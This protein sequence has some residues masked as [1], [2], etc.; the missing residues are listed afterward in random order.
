MCQ[1]HLVCP[2]LQSRAARI[3]K[4]SSCASEAQAA[5]ALATSGPSPIQA[6]HDFM[7]ST[8]RPDLCY[9]WLGPW[10][11]ETNILECHSASVLRSAGKSSFSHASIPDVTAGYDLKPNDLQFPGIRITPMRRGAR[12]SSSSLV[13]REELN[14]YRGDTVLLNSGDASDRSPWVAL[15]EDLWHDADKDKPCMLVR[16]FYR[17]QGMYSVK[18]AV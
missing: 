10:D 2:A 12:T 16:W 14:I 6:C 11:D 3:T 1:Y 17:F 4:N 13:R 18:R 5:T 7:S 9:Q 15:V 8:E